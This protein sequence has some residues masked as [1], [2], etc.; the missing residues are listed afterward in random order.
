MN[1]KGRRE[2]LKILGRKVIR[3]SKLEQLLDRRMRELRPWLK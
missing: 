2:A 1:R 3:G